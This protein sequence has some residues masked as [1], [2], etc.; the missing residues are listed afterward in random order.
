MK[1]IRRILE[2]SKRT[3][4]RVIITDPE[5]ED[6]FVVMGLDQYEG[7]LGPGKVERVE[8]TEKVERTGR[9]DGPSL[10][11]DRDIRPLQPK[12]EDAPPPDLFDLMKPANEAGDTWDIG[13]MSD[14]EREDVLR[15]F[16]AYQGEE[17]KDAP[18]SPGMN[19][20]SAKKDSFDEDQFYLEPVE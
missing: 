14:G 9:M 5:G 16:M 20:N 15:Q 17:E 7:L 11:Q 3:G 12:D 19:L 4:D 18:K 6:A 2:L 1:N 13:K 10:R 8:N